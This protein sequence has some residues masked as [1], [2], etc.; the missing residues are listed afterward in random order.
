MFSDLEKNQFFFE[1]LCTQTHEITSLGREFGILAQRKNKTTMLAANQCQ[2]TIRLRRFK[3]N[4]CPRN[5]CSAYPIAAPWSNK[6]KSQIP[7]QTWYLIASIIWPTATYFVS[8]I[9]NDGP[10]MTHALCIVIIHNDG[11]SMTHALCIVIIHNDGPSMT[12][13]LCI[14]KDLTKWLTRKSIRV[15]LEPKKTYFAKTGIG[16]FSQSRERPWSAVA[17]ET[18]ASSLSFRSCYIFLPLIFSCFIF[19]ELLKWDEVALTHMGLLRVLYLAYKSLF[20]A[21]D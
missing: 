6:N 10:S 5:H 15:E 11:P 9:H 4:S 12:H 3:F 1:S 19:S 16:Q 8:V 13:A 20:I 18:L 17:Y 2:Q 14:V 21:V 7:K